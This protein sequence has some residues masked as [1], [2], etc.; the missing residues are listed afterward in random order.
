MSGTVKSALP[1]IPLRSE[2]ERSVMHAR[3]TEATPR[4]RRQA[5]FALILA[6]VSLAARP[7][8]RQRAAAKP[9]ERQAAP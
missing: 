5:G 3:T 1:G 9:S 7:S 4:R 8:A 2:K 6:G